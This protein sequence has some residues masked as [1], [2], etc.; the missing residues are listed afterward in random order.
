MIQSLKQRR[1][2]LVEL[3]LT[4]ENDYVS[5]QV[6]YKAAG[7]DWYTAS[8]YADLEA[9]TALN[10]S[11]FLWNQAQAMGIV[12]LYGKSEPILYWNPYINLGEYVGVVSV[13]VISVT[14]S[15]VIEAVEHMSL[16]PS[17]VIYLQNWA[18]Y[19]GDNASWDPQQGEGNWKLSPAGA[20]GKSSQ[21]GAKYKE[22]LPAFRIPL[23]TVGEYD[24]HFGFGSGTPRFL[25]RT[26][27]EAY[28]RFITPGNSMDLLQSDYGGKQ[29]KEIFWKRCSIDHGYIEITQL[30]ESIVNH[31]D[32]VPLDYVKLVPLEAAETV[33]VEGSDRSAESEGLAWRQKEDSSASKLKTPE[34]ILYYEPYS[35]TLH[36]FHDA[37]TMNSIMLEEFMRLNPQEIN[38]QTIRI[39]MK[40]LHH[41]SF[42]EKLNLPSMTD[43][44]TIID[45]PVKLV[46]SCD[47]LQESIQYMKD[48]M[49][50]HMEDWQ[51]DSALEASNHS[52]NV[53]PVRFTANI[54]MNRPYLGIPELSE[55]FVRD[56][57][58][59]IKDGDLDY[60]VAPVR[61][62]ALAV[63]HELIE[64]YDIDGLV[65]DYMR[66]YANQSVETLIEIIRSTREKLIEKERMTGRKLELKVRI[67]A[68]QPIYYKAMEICV[69][70][71]LLDG[72][73]PSNLVSSEPLPP[74]EHYL[75]LCSGTQVK[76]FGCIDGWK[77]SIGSEARA[78]SL[79][80][81]HTP[82]DLKSYFEH[83]ES[84]GVDGIYMYQGDQFT[85][86]PYLKR[87]FTDK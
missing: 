53:K 33:A 22:Q 41:S 71:H 4:G 85:S 54:G 61:Q 80:M 21:I 79:D 35:Y 62:Y 15:G 5:C 36:G 64:K 72:I 52:S 9:E 17:G 16:E 50:D 3:K 28:R 84:L 26:E 20:G 39:G 29:N 83:Y 45:D 67:P 73:V 7:D 40:S 42:L 2:N 82:N 38:C 25:A 58:Q 60:S 6:L 18:E 44:N 27:G 1:D 19:L 66:H 8:I 56:H 32:F 47:I 12:R 23:N 13:K 10:G 81:A 11:S 14:T 55:K 69:A 43:E 49:K 75:K 30:Q 48:H 70:E 68:D 86:N 59:W 76:V 63:I 24:I 77:W 51:K 31:Y 78:G 74:V 37:E 34:L 57:P 46:N 65:F 87:M